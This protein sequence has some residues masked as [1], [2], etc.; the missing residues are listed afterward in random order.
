MASQDDP[1]A[2]LLEAWHSDTA[3]EGD[4]FRALADPMRRAARKGLRNILAQRPNEDDV[5]EAVYEAFVTL[6]GKGPGAVTRSLRGFASA[7]AYRRGQDRGRT[8]VREREAVARHAWQ[9]QAISPETADE[10]EH[11]AREQRLDRLRGCMPALTEAQRDVIKSV[12]QEQVSLSN[13]TDQRGVS[14]EAGR[15]M[16]NRGLKRLHDC[17]SA[18]SDAQ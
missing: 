14:Y 16:L 2:A 3:T 18:Q 4:L 5:G 12:I 6:I 8:L 7:I 17:I 9:I 15:R 11:E 13:W 1:F 10:D